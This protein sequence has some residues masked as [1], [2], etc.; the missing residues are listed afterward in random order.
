[1]G[2]QEMVVPALTLGRI[3]RQAR[4][5]NDG[6]RAGSGASDAWAHCTSGAQPVIETEWKVGDSRRQLSPLTVSSVAKV[7]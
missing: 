7:V 1:M 4:N 2:L 3:A 5:M 6:N